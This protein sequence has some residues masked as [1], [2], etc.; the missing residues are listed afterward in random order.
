M[1]H[2]VN[3]DEARARLSDLVAMAQAG[4]EIVI[5]EGDKPVARLVSLAPKRTRVPGL[6]RGQV[7]TSGDFDDELT[8][9]F[10]LGTT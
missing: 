9:E 6:N 10:W 5:T 3:V 4:A 8:D 7:W 1:T 2:T